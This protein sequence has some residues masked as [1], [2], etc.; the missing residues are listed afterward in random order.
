MGYSATLLAGETIVLPAHR[1]EEIWK[2]LYKVQENLGTHISWCSPLPEY[3]LR[4][5]SATKRIIEVLTDYGFDP[6]KVDENGNIAIEGWGGDKLGSC[7]EGM[8]EHIIAPYTPNNVTWVMVGEDSV[9]WGEAIR[10]NHMVQ[11]A[12]R[13]T[14]HVEGEKEQDITIW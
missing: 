9:I 4:E 1:H 6:V 8:W 3:E 11:A 12:V 14:L 7:W 2:D 5:G 10:N 13:T